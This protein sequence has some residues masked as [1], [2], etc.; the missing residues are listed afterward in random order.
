MITAFFSVLVRS[1]RLK[2]TVITQGRS[3]S[4]ALREPRRERGR[5]R[6]ALHAELGEHG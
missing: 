2:I 3:V 1:F 4:V 5:L 6:P